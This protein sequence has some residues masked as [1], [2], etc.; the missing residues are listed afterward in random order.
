MKTDEPYK[1]DFTIPPWS[2]QPVKMWIRFFA[3]VWVVLLVVMAP[4]VFWFVLQDGIYSEDILYLL[5]IV[6]GEVYMT[7]LFAHVAFR[8]RAP[9]GWFPWDRLSNK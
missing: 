4:F 6:A 7:M 3:W 9:K 2:G 1:I 5:G 8:G